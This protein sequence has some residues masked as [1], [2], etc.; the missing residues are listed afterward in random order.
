MGAVY[1]NQRKDKRCRLELSGDI[2][3]LGI[4]GHLAACLDSL[5]AA[6]Y[7]RPMVCVRQHRRP[8]GTHGQRLYAD[9]EPLHDVCLERCCRSEEARRLVF[10]REE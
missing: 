7:L 6:G 4:A 5:S 10:V 1:A 8:C 9:V 2:F 3:F